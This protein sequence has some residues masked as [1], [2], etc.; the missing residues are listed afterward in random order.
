MPTPPS[1]RRWQGAL[2]R[3][4]LF[5]LAV[6]CPCFIAMSLLSGCRPKCADAACVSRPEPEDLKG[7]VSWTKNP[8]LDPEVGLW[9]ART[10]CW[11]IGADCPD[12]LTRSHADWHA[13]GSVSLR[14]E[15]DDTGD[16]GCDC[17]AISQGTCTDNRTVRGHPLERIRTGDLEAARIIYE[18]K[19]A[20]VSGCSGIVGAGNIINL[21]LRHPEGAIWVTDI[22]FETVGLNSGFGQ[23]AGPHNLFVSMFSP[24]PQE[25]GNDWYAFQI[26]LERYPEFYTRTRTDDGWDRWDID[27]LALLKRGARF[28]RRDLD[29]YL[30]Q[31]VD[32]VS[33][34]VC[35]GG[36][37]G[38]SASWQ[39]VRYFDIRVKFKP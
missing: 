25:R 12:D 30:W 1:D 37:V 20:G 6:A 9:D 18:R 17:A 33:E 38:Q 24:L 32:V 35:V 16:M 21:W 22:Y 19:D 2:L 7:Y 27:L 13:D 36:K 34:D 39:E 11:T 3:R 4:L 15:D 28:S 14:A 29:D 10:W 23:R 8:E 31:N 26:K 5:G